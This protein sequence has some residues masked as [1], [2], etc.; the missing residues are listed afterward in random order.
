MFYIIRI[1]F[2]VFVVL[3]LGFIVIK[4]FRKQVAKGKK[5]TKLQYYV[6]VYSIMLSVF[7]LSALSFIP[8]EA[9]FI[10][11]DSVE[12]SLKY[13]WIDTKDITIH[14]EDDC[15][16]AVRGRRDL[17]SFDKND[18][19]Y[20]FVNYHSKKHH[21]H[22]YDDDMYLDLYS[23][24]QK[25]DNKTFYLLNYR[26]RDYQEGYIDCESLDFNYFAQP[27][28]ELKEFDYFTNN[29]IVYQEYAICDGEPLETINL[30]YGDLQ[31][32]LFRH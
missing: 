10:R 26:K 17:Y 8:F 28:Y 1:I 30:R 2:I 32:T 23:M 24:Y 5:Y 21:Y 16:F 18:D 27:E 29:S 19:G 7:L 11:F 13:K 15:A 14:Y 3:P 4:H 31:E 12:E 22:V 9:S 20:S 6:I 25:D